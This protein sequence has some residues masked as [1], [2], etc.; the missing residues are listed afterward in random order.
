MQCAKKDSGMDLATQP[1]CWIYR[2]L[3]SEWDDDFM[4]SSSFQDGKFTPCKIHMEPQHGG[5]EDD[6][7][8]FNWLIFRFHVNFPGCKRCGALDRNN[9]K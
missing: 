5:L 4:I 9:W 2:Y 3:N 8:D 6:F 1:V 7:P